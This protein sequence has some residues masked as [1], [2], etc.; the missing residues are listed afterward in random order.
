[1][2]IFFNSV[3]E[4]QWV[5]ITAVI[6]FL[7]IITTLLSTIYINKK[8]RKA[9]VKSTTKVEWINKIIQLSAEYINDYQLI[10]IEIR[11]IF[12]MKIAKRENTFINKEDVITYDPIE[13]LKHQKNVNNR[14]RYNKEIQKSSEEFNERIRRINYVASQLLLYFMDSSESQ[15]PQI[16]IGKLRN[17]SEEIVGFINTDI[18]K[19]A[20]A[21]DS[22]ELGKELKGHLAALDEL[23][24]EFQKSMSDYLSSELKEVEKRI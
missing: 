17:K 21:S 20:N 19:E 2:S 23:T 15:Q 6:S 3:G 10:G 9:N 16:L 4:F 18:G 22:D 12:V 1:M 24:K 13:A 5:S 7:G 14:Q 11:N 8:T